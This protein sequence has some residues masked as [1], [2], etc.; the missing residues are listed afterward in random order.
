[1]AEPQHRPLEALTVT[2]MGRASQLHNWATSKQVHDI[3]FHPRRWFSRRGYTEK[4]V[5][6]AM[7]VIEHTLQGY[8]HFVDRIIAASLK[9][10]VNGDSIR[11][12]LQS[13]LRELG[14]EKTKGS[15]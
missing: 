6:D 12:E 1:M 9:T 8:E 2:E 15:L 14:K 10:S 5:D 13:A 3:W 7:D 4:S 11:L